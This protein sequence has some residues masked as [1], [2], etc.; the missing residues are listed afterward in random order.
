[1][2]STTARY[3]IYT[4]HANYSTVTSTAW[5]QRESTTTRYPTKSSTQWYTEYQTSTSTPWY[6]RDSTTTR[7][8]TKSSTQWYPWYTE[9]QTSTSTPW[10]QRESTTTRYPTQSST[11]WYQR[12]STTTRYPT[13]SSTQRYPWYTEYQNSTSTPVAAT[14]DFYWTSTSS[15]YPNVTWPSSYI[16]VKPFTTISIPRAKDVVLQGTSEPSDFSVEFNCGSSMMHYVSINVTNMTLTVDSTGDCSITIRAYEFRII[17]IGAVVSLTTSDYLK[18]NQLTI[19]TSDAS[20]IT[21]NNITYEVVEV[22]LLKSSNV[23]L[24]GSTQQLQVIQLGQGTFDS[25][26]LST[27]HATLFTNNY[28][29]VKI[30]SNNYLSLSVGRMGNII[31]CSPYG[32]IKT[33]RTMNYNSRNIV[34]HCD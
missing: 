8:P 31:W 28:G 13:Q 3:P 30:K 34:Y 21:L 14:E 18:G 17:Q 12:E 2:V 7:Y 29:L 25:R 10:Y 4:D 26:S 24:S 33:E 23:T 32:D 15:Q 9:Y 5:Y 22:L 6:Q 20:Q 16:A 1:M 27:D 11:P 19:E